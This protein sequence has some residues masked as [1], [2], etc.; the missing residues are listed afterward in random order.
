M[1]ATVQN[2]KD[3]TGYDVSLETVRRAQGIVEAFAGRTEI[4]VRSVNDRELLRLATAYQAAYMSNNYERT[5]EQVGV[6]QMAQTDGMI[7]LDTDNGAPHL[8][9][10][11]AFVIKRLSWKQS[12]SIKTGPVFNGPQRAY[13][14]SRD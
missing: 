9:P 2:V 14:W 7:T 5:F 4:A 3:F 1:F 6:K 13:D 10:M 11:A 12:R 8:A